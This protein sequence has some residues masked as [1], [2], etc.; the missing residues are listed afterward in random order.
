MQLTDIMKTLPPAEKEQLLVAF[1][2]EETYLIALPDDY[3]IG[4][5]VANP[6]PNSLW[7]LERKGYWC[8][9][10]KMKENTNDK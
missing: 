7:I 9:G 3:F 5:H 1:N 10:K 2:N 6:A 8:F 4:V